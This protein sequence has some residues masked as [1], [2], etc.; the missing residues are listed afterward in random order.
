MATTSRISKA[1]LAAVVVAAGTVAGLATPADA[2]G[3]AGNAS[4]SSSGVLVFT[5]GSNVA[6]RLTVTR[7]TALGRSAIVLRDTAASIAAGANC[8]SA[9]ADTVACDESRVSR[10][11]IS[12]GNFSDVVTVSADISKDATID[13][14]SGED[15]LTGGSGRDSLT[16]G[17]GFD[18]LFHSRGADTFSGGPEVDLVSYFR[19]AS[20][21]TVSIDNLA[22]DGPAGEGDNVRPDV[23]QVNGTQSH[24]DTLTGDDTADAF[25]PFGGGSTINGGGGDDQLLS[26][27]TGADRFNGGP[28]TDIVSYERSRD[29]G[30]T[31]TLD[32]V[33]ND[34]QSGEGDD[35]EADVEE[36]VGTD[37]ADV[38]EGNGSDNGF[39]GRGGNDTIR[40]RG[41]NDTLYGDSGFDTLLGGTGTDTCYVGPDGGDTDDCEAGDDED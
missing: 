10:L 15:D 3:T 29:Q 22:N 8:V 37:Y 13:G 25:V 6:N 33:A 19:A 2:A 34:G 27:P 14:G 40:G 12:T 9:S 11:S 31:V 30:V 32:G 18:R 35:I 38:L 5:A 21:V 4:V 1:V 23:E 28:G 17:T 39:G 41:G 16:G 20:G 26:L 36:V 7:E 24:F